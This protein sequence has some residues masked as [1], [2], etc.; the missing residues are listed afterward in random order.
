MYLY[1]VCRYR[2]YRDNNILCSGTTVGCQDVYVRHINCEL[3][4]LINVSLMSP[5]PLPAALLIP[6]TAARPPRE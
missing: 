3:V 5:V 6:A 1:T 4:V 2:V